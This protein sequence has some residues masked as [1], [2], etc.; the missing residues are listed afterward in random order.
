MRTFRVLVAGATLALIAATASAASMPTVD[1]PTSL[2]WVA[3]P[4]N[5]SMAVLYGNPSKP[6]FYV[7]RMKLPANWM[8]PVHSHPTQENVTVISGTLYAGIGKRVD[9]AK[10]MTFPAGSF[11]AMPAGVLHYAFTK[12]GPV[13]I[14]IDGQGPS[15]NDMLKK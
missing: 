4:G 1:M 9:K 5:F 12:S 6:G 8:F 13:I 14:Q 7:M 10:A 3:Q 2:H 11:V 15:R